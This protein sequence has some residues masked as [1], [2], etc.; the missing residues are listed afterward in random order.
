MINLFYQNKI[1]P[2]LSRTFSDKRGKNS[3]ITLTARKYPGSMNEVFMSGLSQGQLTQFTQ[4]MDTTL[5]LI[6]VDAPKVALIL[7]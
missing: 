7:L 3:V 2:K 5:D 6:P 4:R 1:M